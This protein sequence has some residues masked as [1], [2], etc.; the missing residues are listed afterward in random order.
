MEGEPKEEKRERCPPQR[1][2]AA[3]GG[4]DGASG[5]SSGSAACAMALATANEAAPIGSAAE[6][7]AEEAP[8]VGGRPKGGGEG[9]FMELDG[10]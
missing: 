10:C 2:R 5:V 1:P 4:G 6:V 9:N 3:R 8:L 7:E